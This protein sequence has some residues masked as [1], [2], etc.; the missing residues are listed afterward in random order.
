VIAYKIGG[1]GLAGVSGG[2]R[3]KLNNQKSRASAWR[4]ALSSVE[5]HFRV[6]RLRVGVSN[7]T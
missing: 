7:L 3:N 2:F 5:S 4:A 6:T 1:L